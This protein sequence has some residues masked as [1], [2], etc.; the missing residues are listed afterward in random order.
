MYLASFCLSLILTLVRGSRND[1]LLITHT[2]D[3]WDGGNCIL[4]QVSDGERP[5]ISNEL[6]AEL[7]ER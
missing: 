2:L 4:G 1:D 6:I 5:T 7:H 3:S